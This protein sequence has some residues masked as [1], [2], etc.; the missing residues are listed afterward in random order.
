MFHILNSLLSENKDFV[1][2]EITDSLDSS[3]IIGHH[4]VFKLKKPSTKEFQE[5]LNYFRDTCGFTKIPIAFC[6]VVI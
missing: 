1:Y 3:K 4:L 2:S 6:F 5:H